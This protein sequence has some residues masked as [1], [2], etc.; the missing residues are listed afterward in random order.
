MSPPRFQGGC[1]SSGTPGVR[2]IH[3]RNSR[4]G[5]SPTPSPRN[6]GCHSSLRLEVHRFPRFGHCH[7]MQPGAT[8]HT[9]S[10]VG[11]RNGGSHWSLHLYSPGPRIGCRCGGSLSTLGIYRNVGWKSACIVSLVLRFLKHLSP[12]RESASREGFSHTSNCFRQGFQSVSQQPWPGFMYLLHDLQFSLTAPYP[13]GIYLW[14][15]RRGCQNLHV[16]LHHSS[17]SVEP[18][19]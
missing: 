2:C 17:F 13:S 9:T 6:C 5:D 1:H 16:R 8:P 19:A 15:A 10:G 3:V 12:S 14:L 18:T 11:S 7:G 4:G